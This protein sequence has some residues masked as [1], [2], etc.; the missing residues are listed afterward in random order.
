M[1]L[2]LSDFYAAIT[3]PRLS[4]P[5]YGSVKVTGYF[6]P[7]SVA[8]Y[9]CKPGFRLVGASTRKCL[10][11]GYW[12]GKA[13]TCR[14]KDIYQS[15]RIIYCLLNA[16]ITCPRLSAPKYGSVKVT[17]YFRP[18]SVAKYSCKPGFKLVGT[19]TRKCLSNGYWSGKAPTCQRKNKLQNKK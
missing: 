6:R 1:K 18:G 14:R 5:K 17:G 4:A 11:N 13:P 2:I 3:C 9:S 12:S 7:G 16:A 15:C 8:K 19:S 10:S